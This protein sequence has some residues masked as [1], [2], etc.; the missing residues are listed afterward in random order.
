MRES[1]PYNEIKFDNNVELEDLLNTPHDSDIGY[2]VEL[3]INYP[4]NIKAKQNIFH[5]SSGKKTIPHDFSD[6][7]EEIK[8]DTHTQNKNLICDWSDKKNFLID[9]SLLK[10]LC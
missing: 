6:Y 3:D 8:P 2:F 7:K 4:D 5:C 1:L 10:I 9:Y